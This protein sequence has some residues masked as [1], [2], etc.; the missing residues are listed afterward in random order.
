VPEFEPT[1]IVFA[2]NRFFLC[3]F[4]SAGQPSQRKKW[5]KKKL[6]LACSEKEINQIWS[7]K[8]KGGMNI[9]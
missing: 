8:L 4:S 5:V 7:L 2:C 6:G 1:I 3:A 9:A